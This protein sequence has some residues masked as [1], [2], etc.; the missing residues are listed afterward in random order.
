MSYHFHSN[1]GKQSTLIELLTDVDKRKSYVLYLCSCYF[2]PKSAKTL[3][4]KLSKIVKIEQVYIYIDRKEA[5][6]H[7]KT[8]LKKFSNDR[9]LRPFNVTLEAVETNSLFHSKTYCLFHVD[10][11]CEIT[12]GSLVV[13]SANLTA[14]GVGHKNGNIESFIGT[15]DLYTTEEYHSSFL[16]LETIDIE[17]LNEFNKNQELSFRYSLI[18]EGCFYH[19]WNENLEQYLSVKFKLSKEGKAQIKNDKLVVAGFNLD[20]A[21]ISKRYFQFDDFV[22]SHLNETETLI[23]NYAIETHLGYWIPKEVGNEMISEEF[24]IYKERLFTKLDS[25]I[26]TIQKEIQKDY[27]YLREHNLIEITDEDYFSNDTPLLSKGFSEKVEKLKVNDLR[28]KRIFNKYEIFELPYGIENREAINELFEEILDVAKSKTRKNQT[29]HA[30]LE[31][32]TT[33]DLR[34]IQ[35]LGGRVEDDIWL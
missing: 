33:Y 17:N 31:A 20:T 19:K 35:I 23:R 21:T 12:G 16:D 22:P 9:E 2:T 34:P 24:E 8:V 4:M 13:G 3:I 28:L 1:I 14:N 25:E 32:S 29:V 7:G 5:V 11:D 30:F 27:S 18:K 26:E 10:E 6:K 15:K